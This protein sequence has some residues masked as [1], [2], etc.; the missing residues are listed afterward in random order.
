MTNCTI[1]RIYRYMSD[2]CLPVADQLKPLIRD[3]TVTVHFVDALYKRFLDL[4]TAQLQKTLATATAVK[5]SAEV[6]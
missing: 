3:D 6:S 1:I 2:L 4:K 5:R